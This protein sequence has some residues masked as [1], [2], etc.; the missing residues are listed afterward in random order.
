[1]DRCGIQIPTGPSGTNDFGVSAGVPV[2]V[3]LGSSGRLDTGLEFEFIFA[4]P[5]AII[6]LDLPLAV[7]FNV[8][9]N[10]FLGGRTGLYV[11]DM[12]FDFYTV[13][14]YFQGGYTLNGGNADITAWAGFPRF[15]NG[16][17]VTPDTLWLKS[18]A[19]GFGC[20]R[21]RQRDVT[22]SRIRV[23]SAPASY[24]RRALAFKTT[25][26]SGI[27]QQLE[28]GCGPG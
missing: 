14:L 9:D 28:A 3:R 17:L 23:K 4:D 26:L 13:P 7:N 22:S 25:S 1:M 16:D 18:I 15:L 8:T 24:L 19:F 20:E 2:L 5:D 27:A 21:K 10:V 11:Q 12:D 6:N